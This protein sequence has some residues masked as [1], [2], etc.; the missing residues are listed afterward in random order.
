MYRASS[1][2]RNSTAL[3]TSFAAQALTSTTVR[4]RTLPASTCTATSAARSSG[5]VVEM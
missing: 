2:T 5:T 3:L 1:E 4:P